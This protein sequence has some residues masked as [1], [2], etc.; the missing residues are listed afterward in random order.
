MTE[1][2]EDLY[3]L[4]LQLA[5]E[6]PSAKATRRLHELLVLCCAEGC[7][8]QGG[9]FGN[10]MSQVDFLCKRYKL[11]ADER[12][13]MQDLRRH[14]NSSGPVDATEWPY[15]L[16]AMSQL[17]S[18]VTAQ[19]VPGELRRLLPAN[20]RPRQQSLRQAQHYVRCI[21]Q[22][23]DEHHI[24]ALSDD[25]ELTI[26][27]STIRQGRDFN[28]LRRLLREGM[29]LNLLDCQ[30]DQQTL[31]PGLVVVEPDF[32][33]DIS[34]IAACFTDYGH[35]PLLY[36]LNRLKPKANTQAILLG[37]FAGTALD[38][39]IHQQGKSASL[40][41]SLTRSFR[42]Q[43]LRFCAC[44]DLQPEAFKTAA[45]Q[46]IRNIEEAVQILFNETPSDDQRPYDRDDALLE[47]S[48]VCEQLGLQGRV[49][50]MTT[51]LWLLVE[52]KAGK[53]Q[54][55]ER[56]SHDSHGRQ[57][58]SHYVQ[59]LL[60]Y[61]ILRY[62]FH[63][64]DKSVDI[65]LLYS[66]YPA[67]QGLLAV[68]FYRQLFAEA[69]CLRNQIVATE[70]LIAREGFGR[71]MPHLSLQTIYKNAQRDRFFHQYIEPGINALQALY[72]SLTPLERAYYERMMTF[73]YREQACQRLGSSES[74]LHHSK[75]AMSDLWQM[76]LSEKQETGNIFTD[77][78]VTALEQS[79]EQ[80]GYDTVRLSITAHDDDFTPN[81]RRGDIVSLY[82]YNG[83]PD[84]RNS[85]LYKASLMELG[86]D[87][88]TLRL[89]EAQ[90]SP[91]LLAGEGAT[92]AVE[93]AATDTSASADIRSLQQFI[94]AA[95]D[96]KALLLGQRTPRAD[97]TITRLSRSYHPAYDELLLR[98]R[99]SLDYFLLVGPPGTGKTSMALRFLVSEEQ[100][101]G[102]LLMAYTNRA[103]DEIC[104]MLTSAGFDYLRI[105]SESSCEPRFRDHLL[106]S[107]LADC[108]KLSDMRRHICQ[109]PIIVGTTST[110]Q[111]RQEIFHLRH[112][113]RCIVDEASQIL[114]P[115]LIGLLASAQIDRFI[116]IGDHKQLP[117]VV[118]QSEEDARVS[119]PCLLQIGL[120]D[121]RQ[122][123]FERLLRWEQQ[124]GR[125]QFVGTLHYQ[126]RMHPDVARFPVTAFYAR[127]QLQ[128]V[129]L[130]H[131]QAASLGYSLPP[132]DALDALLCSQRVLFI[133]S[134]DA[135]TPAEHLAS[136]KVNA[137][138]ARI[139]ADLLQ[140]IHRFYGQHFSPI[141][142]V[143]VIVPYRN[144][145]AR[146]RQEIAR[147]GIPQL[148][149][150]TI[151]TV[152]RYQGSQRD[153]IIYSFTVS[154]AYQLD[155]L[156]AN[157][158]M[159]HGQLI[160][161]KLNV[162]LT[163]ARCQMLMTGRADILRS[164]P[165]LNRLI[166]TASPSPYDERRESQ[167]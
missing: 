5:V 146:I 73:V 132:R 142:T 19:S 23:W 155:F 52:Q 51:D 46:Q 10:L 9:A 43:A 11:T 40:S 152:E 137:T 115:A 128:P 101:G 18:A 163:R 17:I 65:R 121:C 42:E 81:F 70:L 69:I 48:F 84:M 91:R 99:Q 3:R 117:A 103:V 108:Q 53:N 45:T 127:E 164:N 97:T 26:D 22:T 147:I 119:E 83:Q 116:L 44:D 12:L 98:A 54:K 100:E 58:E 80:G 109:P 145:I 33:I 15:D 82:R 25:G 71:I 88:I 167:Q 24:H 13:D 130:P 34:S 86:T 35:H 50:L 4:C 104:A 165:L 32:L 120:N 144:Q 149:D 140:R 166:E 62:N 96:R 16:R 110:I 21:V 156:T 55:I 27:Y 85:I 36:T 122:S 107:A 90:Q 159:E 113:A 141:Q 129:P 133:D 153:V 47:P 126:G 20:S 94:S 124:C 49:D 59:L 61:G 31:V 123:L 93:H 136:D 39:L 57:I 38:D 1:A 92:W 66:R 118:Q 135:A 30:W 8:R 74:R 64:T 68:N 105:G 37:N 154:H 79:S 125:T 87:I 138:E 139:V 63:R 89:T 114:E 75:G 72:A 2:T 162:A 28:Y 151:D 112:F 29:Q 111:A 60:Y 78:T 160:D 148:L 102:L 7:R 67:A 41:R 14:S 76:P 157:T 131:Q 161:R 95:P 143:G 134:T 56:Q 158:F 106:E 6:G 77:L 150:V